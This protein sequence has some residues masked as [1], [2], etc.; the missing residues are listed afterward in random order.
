MRDPPAHTSKRDLRAAHL[1]SLCRWQCLLHVMYEHTAAVHTA[2]TCVCASF[3]GS[4]DGTTVV[5]PYCLVVQANRRSLSIHQ[6]AHTR[7][8]CLPHTYLV[9]MMAVHVM[10]VHTAAV[11][12]ADCTHT[13][14]HTRLHAFIISVCVSSIRWL[15]F[16]LP[17]SWKCILKSSKHVCVCVCFEHSMALVVTVHEPCLL[18]TSPS[19]RD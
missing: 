10:Y 11:H 19:P 6:T 2:A 13:T 4:S 18:Y 15:F 14:A 9:C 8:I 3:D 17:C 12:T 7:V 1:S 5:I 16:L